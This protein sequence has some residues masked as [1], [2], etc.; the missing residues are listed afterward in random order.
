[1]VVAGAIGGLIVGAI[2]VSGP[3]AVVAGAAAGAVGARV[4]SKCRELRKDERVAHE[5]LAASVLDYLSGVR[6]RLWC[7]LWISWEIPLLPSS[8]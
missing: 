7:V 6:E 3:V 8:I 4:I 2:M 1:M 5:R